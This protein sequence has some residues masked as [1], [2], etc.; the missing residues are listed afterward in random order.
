MVGF[1]DANRPLANDGA[2]SDKGAFGR[3][4]QLVERLLYTQ[5]VGGSSPSP[6]TTPALT[7]STRGAATR[8]T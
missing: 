1:I 8:N 5:D 7:G 3:L 2:R 4:A 6:P